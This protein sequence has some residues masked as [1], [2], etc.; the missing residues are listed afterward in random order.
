MILVFARVPKETSEKIYLE[1]LK[2]K[3]ALSISIVDTKTIDQELNLKEDSI[4]IIKTRKDLFNRILQVIKSIDAS[5][6]EIFSVKVIDIDPEFYQ[7]LESET[8]LKKIREAE[9]A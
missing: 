3:L 9:N 5:I 8:S 6:N 2:K 4:L 7:L 1:I